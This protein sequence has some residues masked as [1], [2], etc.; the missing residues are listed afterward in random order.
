MG[1]RTSRGFIPIG[2]IL[3]AVIIVAIVGIG[4]FVANRPKATEQSAGAVATQ[5]PETKPA[6]SSLKNFYDCFETEGRTYRPGKPNRCVAQGQTF[7]EPTE[8]TDQNVRGADRLPA[9]V[10]GQV[11]TAASRN[12]SKCSKDNQ[13]EANVPVTQVLSVLGND[14]TFIALSCDNNNNEI[15]MKQDDGTWKMISRSNQQ[16]SCALA[17]QYQIPK[18]LFL[19]SENPSDHDT[20]CLQ[21][22]GSESQIPYTYKPSSTVQATE[23]AES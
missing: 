3:V 11:F 23:D 19:T 5:K 12:F 10:R 20:A 9:G 17:D 13:D 8:F 14:W 21:A 16:V 15:Y 22:D 2:Y 6:T 4:V 1:K 18:E 7:D